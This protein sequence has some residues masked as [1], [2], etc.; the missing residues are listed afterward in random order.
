MYHS[1]TNVYILCMYHYLL[2]SPFI[3]YTYIILCIVFINSCKTPIP[4]LFFF[5]NSFFIFIYFY[6]Y[7]FFYL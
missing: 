2:S 5:T 7:Y 3:F 1:P 6:Y 4:L